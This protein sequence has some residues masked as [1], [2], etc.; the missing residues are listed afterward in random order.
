MNE[1]PAPAKINLHLRVTG[2]TAQGYHLLD[3]SF[4]YVDACDIL[5]IAPA[6]DLRV[7]CSDPTLSGENNLVFR[8][9][10]ALRDRYRIGDGLHVLVEK[11][12]PA[13]AGLGGGSS[14]AAT[15]LVVANKLWGLGLASRELCLFAAPFGADIPCFLFG[16]ASLAQG[17]GDRLAPLQ[18]PAGDQHV[19]LAHPGPGLSTA[20][21]FACFDRTHKDRPDAWTPAELTTIGAKV[22]IPAGWRD[23]VAQQLP[24]GENMLEDISVGM[25][26]ELARLL[27][28]MRRIQPSSWMS[29]SGTAC[30]ALCDSAAQAESMAGRLAAEGLAAWTH[31]GK[32]LARHPLHDSGMQPSD[33]GVAKR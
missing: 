30:V 18:L 25:C 31:A 24:L 32:L 21:V 11:H 16:R 4:A 10:Q 20:E 9:L 22:T 3:T 26:P 6:P 1:C 14:D 29:G 27:A 23:G 7:S 28:E 13:Q 15:A 33:W 5:H 17:T 12:L 2:R 8:V 19:V